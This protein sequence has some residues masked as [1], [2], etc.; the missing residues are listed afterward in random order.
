MKTIEFLAITI[1]QASGS[2][3]KNTANVYKEVFNDVLGY[4]CLILIFLIGLVVLIKIMSGKIP[5]DYLLEEHGGG[6]SMSRFQLLIFTFVVALSLLLIVVSKGDFPKDIPTNV[7]LLVG[8][9]GSTYGVSKG[10][11]AGGGLDKKGPATPP[12]PPPP[13]PKVN[14]PPAG[15]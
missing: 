11:Q 6:A 7:L 10:I 13:P 15:Q 8:I 2:A 3:D 12:P 5:L 4:A 1:F 14:P 9:S